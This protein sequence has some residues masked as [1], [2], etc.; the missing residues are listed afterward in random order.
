MGRRLYVGNLSFGT[1]EETLRAAFSEDGRTV[2]EVRMMAKGRSRR[3]RGFAFLDMDSEENAQA[4]MEAHDGMELDGRKLQVHE[5]KEQVIRSGRRSGGF[6]RG[7][8]GR[9]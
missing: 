3:P 7:G 9:W 2:T 6:G 4:A 8:H 1:T 5:A